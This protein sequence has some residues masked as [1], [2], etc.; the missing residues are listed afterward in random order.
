MIVEFL[1]NKR[2]VK[3]L[4]KGLLSMMLSLIIGLS[5]LAII[6]YVSP[7]AEAATQYTSGYYT[8]ERLDSVHAKI[9]DVDSNISGAVTIPE[10]LDGYTVSV[11]DNYAFAWLREITRVTIPSGVTTINAC[12]FYGCSKLNYISL[13]DSLMYIKNYAFENCDALTSI[14]IP[15]G[16]LSL[17]NGV[18]M[19][20]DSLSKVTFGAKVSVLGDYLFDGC[21]KLSSFSVS[22]SNSYLKVSNGALINGYKLVAYPP[23]KATTN[24]TLPSGITSVERGAFSGCKN[25]KTV[26]V[27]SN[28]VEIS[29]YAF[30]NCTNLTSV[31]LPSSVKK[32]NGGAFSYCS[33]L[34]TIDTSNVNYLGYSAFSGCSS[35]TSIS[36]SNVNHWDYSVFSGCSSLTSVSIPKNASEIPASAF[37][38]CSS[39]KTITVPNT[40]K[41]VGSR[42]FYNCTSLSS[43]SLPTGITEI[44]GSAFDKTAYYNNSSNWSSNGL[45]YKGNYL[46]SGDKATGDVAIKNG[47]VLIAGSAFNSNDTITSV[48][49]PDSVEIICDSAFENCKELYSVKLGNRVTTIGDSAFSNCDKLTNVKFN[50][51]VTQI[52][53]YAFAWSENIEDVALPSSVTTIAYGTFQGCTNL[54]NVHISNSIKKIDGCAFRDCD[55]LKKVYYLG[56]SDD[57]KTVHV[58]LYRNDGLSNAEILFNSLIKVMSYNVYVENEDV[59]GYDCSYETRLRYIVQSINN[60]MPDSIGLQEV[61]SD[62]RFMLENYEDLNGGILAA[63]YAGVG[64]YR[65][66]RNN[67]GKKINSEASL[68][69]YNKNK[70]TLEKEGTFWLSESGEKNSIHSKAE[71]PRVCTYALLKNKETGLEYLHVNTHIEHN[72]TGKDEINSNEAAIFSSEKIID[73]VDKKF[74]NVPVVITGDFNQK[75]GSVPYNNFIDAGYTDTRN[76][77]SGNVN[78]YSNCYQGGS[79]SVIDHIFV[80]DYFA[81]GINSYKVY[82]EDYSNSAKYGKF[83]LDYPYPSDHHPVIVELEATYFSN[84]I[85]SKNINFGENKTVEVV[86]KNSWFEKSN[87]VYNHELA[88]FCADYVMMGYCEDKDKMETYLKEMGFDTIDC[89]MAAGRDEVNYFIASKN[90]TVNGKTETLV[91]AAFIGSYKDQWYSNFDPYGIERD[92]WKN[93]NAPY[94]DASEKGKVH[95]GFADAREYVYARLKEFITDN[96]INKENMKLLL[97]GHSRGA[98]TANLLAAKLIDE[99]KVSTATVH[100]DDIY[101]YTFATP[102]TALTSLGTQ[103]SSYKKI[104]NIVNPEDFVTKVMLKSWGFGRYGTTYTLPSKKNDDNYKSY[105][106]NMKTLFENYSGKNYDPYKMGELKTYKIIKLFEE[107]VSTLNGLYE[108]KFVYRLK[109][110]TDGYEYKSPFEF[111]KRTLLKYLVDEDMDEI[112]NIVWTCST[113]YKEIIMYFAWPDADL[114]VSIDELYKLSLDPKFEIGGKFKQAHQMETYAAYMNSMTGSQIKQYREA[115]KN[116]VNCPVDIEVYDNTTNELV[117]KITNNVIDETVAS[118]ENAIV[119]DVDG[120]SKSFWLP[121][122]GDYRVVLTGNDEGMMDYTVSDIDSDTGETVRAN[123]FDVEIENDVSMTGTFVSNNTSVEN[124]TLI[125][126][127]NGTINPTEILTENELQNFTVVTVAEGNGIADE[128]LW[129][130]SGDYTTVTAYA[131]EGGLFNGWYDNGKLVSTDINYSFVVKGNRNLVAKFTDFAIKTPST[132]TISYGDSIILHA[133]FVGNQNSLQTNSTN[134]CPYCKDIFTDESEYNKHLADCDGEPNTDTPEQ[135]EQ[136]EQ[137]NIPVQPEQP[138]VTPIKL[139]IEWTAS[140]DNFSYSVSADGKT[141]KISPNKSGETTFTATVYDENENVIGVDTQEMTSK[142][143]FFQKIIAFFKKL[144]GLTKTIPQIYKGIF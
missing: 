51:K 139:Y 107:N 31:S 69:Y 130:T 113:F 105:L 7:T 88:Q 27:S 35:L 70:F 66:S 100:G 8:Y 2:K 125:H 102:N 17:G 71:Y 120:D 14:T 98:A 99:S 6:P 133:D 114:D 80:N 62:M 126:E 39:L 11:I 13:P 77:Y 108:D 44:G 129:V 25:L 79:G 15:N 57:W 131:G 135:P 94:A 116:T 91:F 110:I 140:N 37:Y 85:L 12:A 76:V 18:F 84:T 72:H 136:P 86:F 24:Y 48:T 117:G 34:K 16:V 60:N 121:S 115:Y 124:Y 111:F 61:T 55:N 53:E 75:K 96:N 46:L 20:C 122:N 106:K 9:V 47:S 36:T 137:P 54:K 97:S 22:S 118:G 132:T 30:E 143:G 73:F 119:M 1:S 23:A 81:G 58:D 19:G 134:V 40:I 82:N 89:C 68:I 123:F 64:D 59:N 95:L 74:P 87:E 42:A 56:S 128:E 101:T 26:S 3:R 141:C 5:S 4:A 29:Y 92:N 93:R 144:F 33:S 52:G 45:L 65:G 138:T 21:P 104:F 32:I 112:M 83:A 78:T 38:G 142:A 41:S 10:T 127:E 109:S 103:Q 49:V 90:I 43:F 63:N 50:D 28:V 67:K